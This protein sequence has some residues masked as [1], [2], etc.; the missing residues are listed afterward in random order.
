[1]LQQWDHRNAT[2]VI[3]PLCVGHH[4]QGPGQGGELAQRNV[5]E[6][7]SIHIIRCTLS[8]NRDQGY[9]LPALPPDAQHASCAAVTQE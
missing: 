1:M 2:A 8:I 3:R 7:I 4:Y 9:R 6:S 5:E